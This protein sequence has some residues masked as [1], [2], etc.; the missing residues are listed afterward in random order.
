MNEDHEIYSEPDVHKNSL[1]VVR[2]TGKVLGNV[3]KAL[4]DIKDRRISGL[5]FRRKYLG[6]EFYLEMDQVEMVGE[7]VVF[8][9]SEV[10][11]RELTADSV[12]FGEDIRNLQGTWVYLKGGKP[13]GTLT[14]IEFALPNWQLSHLCLSDNR[15]IKVNAPDVHINHDK[16]IVPQTSQVLPQTEA[17]GLLT[18]LFGGAVVKQARIVLERAL[19]GMP[20]KDRPESLA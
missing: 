1:V 8:V 6:K 10:S 15:I 9:K 11:P 5:S 13:L 3:N 7:D 18:R 2:S 12:P 4:F 14:D 20:V 17:H 19:R 16:I